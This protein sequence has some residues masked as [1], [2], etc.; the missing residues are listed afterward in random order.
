MLFAR[1]AGAVLLGGGCDAEAAVMLAGRCDVFAGWPFALLL[2]L[3]MADVGRCTLSGAA[4]DEGPASGGRPPA[5]AIC[6]RG[7]E[8]LVERLTMSLPCT[9]RLSVDFLR[10]LVSMWSGVVCPGHWLVVVSHA[11]AGLDSTVGIRCELYHITD[12]DIDDTEKP[13]V[14]LLELLLVKDLDGQYAVLIHAAIATT[15][16]VW[17]CISRRRKQSLEDAH[18][19][20][21]SFQ[22]GH[23][24]RLDT[25]VVCVCSPLMVATANGSGKPVYDPG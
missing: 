6:P 3:A 20:K 23:R 15:G 12:P 18:K 4:R 1:A 5:P 22:Y 13:L 21:L 14:L 16:S 11:R 9:T 25:A 24:V 2:G 10:S 7:A 17:E 8:R 19:S